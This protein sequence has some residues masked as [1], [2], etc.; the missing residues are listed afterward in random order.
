MPMIRQDYE[1]N[2]RR[3]AAR[4]ETAFRLHLLP[5]LG[6]VTMAN[7]PGAAFGYVTSRRLE[8]AAPATI[9]Y[10]LSD[11]RRMLNLACKAGRIRQ[12]PSLPSIRVDNA[13]TGFFEDWQVRAV[14]RELPRYM[15]DA[16]M[17]A[18]HTGWRREEVFG[19]TWDDVD[20]SARMVRL[21]PGSTKSRKG[22]MFPYGRH[23]AILAIIERRERRRRGPFVFHY[24]GQRVRFIWYTWNRACD[25]A[26]LSGKLFHDLRRTCARNMER[27]GVPRTVAMRL[28]GLET[29]EMYRRYSIVNER[30][31]D[32]AVARMDHYSR[33]R[34]TVLHR[35]T[36]V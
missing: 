28:I 14:V 29:E 16:T 12:R 1:V 10:E 33:R 27:A 4:M 3:S 21:A 2:G 7:L 36:R 6:D 24:E 13:R 30:D 11:L 34:G 9:R 26:G 20:L 19:L 35:F 15:G 17:F 22:R 8:K 5:A 18:Y 31:L 23:A 25:R 32:G